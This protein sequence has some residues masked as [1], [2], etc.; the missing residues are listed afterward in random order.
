MGEYLLTNPSDYCTI[1]IGNLFSIS[2]KYW[3]PPL[4]E[5]KEIA[6][7]ILEQLLGLSPDEALKLSD[8]QITY[9]Q[10]RA[11][12]VYLTNP[13]VQQAMKQALGPTGTAIRSQL[14]SSGQGGAG[15]GVPPTP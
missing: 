12:I 4:G 7:A 8:Q 9:L 2:T 5:R 6:M 13:D 3:I 10:E 15:T 1:D 11:K 14:G